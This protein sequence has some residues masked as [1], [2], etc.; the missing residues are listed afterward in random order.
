MSALPPKADI[1]WP[2]RHVRFVPKAAFRP[3]GRNAFA[4]VIATKKLVHVVDVAADPAYVEDRNPS[5]NRTR[6][7]IRRKGGSRREHRRQ[8]KEG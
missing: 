2:G 7:V 1:A 8:A 3:S 6:R 5:M 4:R